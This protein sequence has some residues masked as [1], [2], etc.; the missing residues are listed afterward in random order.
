[1]RYLKTRPAIHFTLIV[2]VLLVL[3]STVR[4][5]FTLPMTGSVKTL[6]GCNA[7][8]GAQLWRTGGGHRVCPRS[9]I[10]DAVQELLECLKRHAGA[11]HTDFG[12]ERPLIERYG[13][14]L[15]GVGLELTRLPGVS[16]RHADRWMVKR[17]TLEANA[18]VAQ[19]LEKSNNCG[20]LALIQANV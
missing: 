13:P 17:S 6:P 14:A 10:P 15:R 18:V 9:V 1:C 5:T 4:T 19:R 11:I 8:P 3:P 20:T 2:T 12:N 7:L 16:V